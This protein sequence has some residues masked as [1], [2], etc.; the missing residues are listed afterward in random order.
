MVVLGGFHVPNQINVPKSGPTLDLITLV[1]HYF[2]N[3][4]ETK[5]NN[6]S[7]NLQVIFP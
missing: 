1:S 6:T 7:P 5:L 3:L 4:P 2:K